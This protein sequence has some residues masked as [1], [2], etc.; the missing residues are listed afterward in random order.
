MNTIG[1]ATV[2]SNQPRAG[3]PVEA[4]EAFAVR[5]KMATPMVSATM[6]LPLAA[7]VRELMIA[8]ANNGYMFGMR[9][10]KGTLRGPV[11]ELPSTG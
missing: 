10:L 3:K 8:A 6:S 4:D 1:H 2:H 9:N 11:R 7:N 5:M